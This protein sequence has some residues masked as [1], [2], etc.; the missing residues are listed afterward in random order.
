MKNEFEEGQTR[1]HCFGMM[2]WARKEENQQAWGILKS[3]HLDHLVWRHTEGRARTRQDEG[4]DEALVSSSVSL[5]KS[6]PQF[7]FHIL[8]FL[9]FFF[10]PDAIYVFSYAKCMSWVSTLC[11]ALHLF[12][13]AEV[14]WV[15]LFELDRKTQNPGQGQ[16]EE[17]VIQF[18]NWNLNPSY[19]NLATFI[20]LAGLCWT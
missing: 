5:W 11:Q 6:L 9:F 12:K 13:K 3:Y 16:F 4:R 15:Q 7:L 19:N 17:H 1:R 14:L 2:V 20:H 10:H 8:G 18:L